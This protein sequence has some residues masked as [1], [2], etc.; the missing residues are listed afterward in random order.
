MGATRETRRIDAPSAGQDEV[1]HF[2]AGDLSDPHRVLGAHP[3]V[4]NGVDGSIVRA[5]HPDAVAAVCIVASGRTFPL[6]GAED[7]DGL[8]AAF[9]P[10]VTVPA[11]YRIRFYF[12][13]GTSWE[14]GDPYRFLP[15]LGDVDLHLFNEGRHRRLWNVMGA[16]PRTIDGEEGVAFAV[17]APNAR[18][19]SVVG[20]F[21][22]WDGRVFPMRP[23]GS[24]GIY[25]L[26]VPGVEP[27]S[28]YKFELLTREGQLRTKTDPF[29]FAMELP[30][31]TA[32]RVVSLDQYHWRDS[33]WMTTRAQRDA[34][35]EPMAVYEV[36]LGSWARVPEA[37]R[38]WLSYR[39]IAP[40]LAEHARG[41]GFTHI[42]LLPI[43]EHPFSGSWGYQVSGYYAPTARFGTPDDFRFFVD[44]CHRAGLGVILDWVPAH[45][46]KDDFALRRYDGTALYEHQDPRLGEH[47]DWGTLIFNYGRAEVRNFLTANA[48]YWLSEFHIDGLRVDAV[49]S[50]LYLDYSRKAGEW[51]PNRYGGR[52]NLEAIDFL[53]ETNELVRTEHPGCIMVAEESTAWPGV[54][55]PASEGGLGFTFKWNMGWM[56]DTLAYFSEDPIHRSYHQDQLTFAMLY[57]YTEHF[58]NPLSHDEVVHGKRS[59]LDKMPGD[60]W[61]KFANLRLLLTYQYTRPGKKL[62]FMGTELAPWREWNHDLSLDWHLAREPERQAFGCFLR[63]LGALYRDTP[64]LWRMDPDPIGFSWIDA[65]DRA[66]SVMSYVRSDGDSHVVVVLNMTPVP[67][68]N[69]RIGAPFAGTYSRRF[70]SDDRRYGGSEVETAE[71]VST[72]AV[73]MHGYPHSVS[74]T[75]PPLGALVLSPE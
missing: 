46:P 4:V 44:T 51:L 9:L 6:D 49:A 40:K 32:S 69:Y 19:A 25:E 37:G 22:N 43:M 72:E 29:A 20:D 66:S 63:E 35:R 16:H 30:P 57:E 70:S 33:A 24:S 68:E 60:V 13:D 45:F 50:M 12:P 38:R 75:L 73:P 3:A 31:G 55:R 61:Q 18:R 41:L 39:E 54:T 42:E 7:G 14:H 21:C 74:L 11:H 2:L 28:L 17:W 10:G 26:F 67:R 1:A 34:L 71:R 58:I 47:P 8:F 62:L 36:H 15:T 23:L 65:S 64:S 5:F 48:L 56:H 53:R 27:G 52:E 59:L